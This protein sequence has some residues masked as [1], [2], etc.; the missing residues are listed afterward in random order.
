MTMIRAVATESRPTRCHRSTAADASTSANAPYVAVALNECPL[1]N[2]YVVNWMNGSSSSGRPRRK[3]ALSAWLR[4]TLPA[5]AATTKIAAP[6]RPRR[7][8]SSAAS[9]AIGPSTIALPAYVIDLHDVD[10]DVRRAPPH[11]VH[12]A[13]VEPVR[14]RP[15]EHR[16][17]DDDEGSAGDGEHRHVHAC[18]VP[19]RRHLRTIPGT[20]RLDA[21]V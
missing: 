14:A 6:V 1:G 10:Q 15:E 9:T 18:R 7:M 13:D 11:P 5:H 4:S 12:R 16:R 3:S 19:A 8:K 17:G 21:V 2:A 20:A